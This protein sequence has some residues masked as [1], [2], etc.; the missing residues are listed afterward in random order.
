MFVIHFFT[1]LYHN[2]EER[3]EGRNLQVQNELCDGFLY[4]TWDVDDIL[5]N[6]CENKRQPWIVLS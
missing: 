6:L 4:W 3:I 2:K 5:H 1:L